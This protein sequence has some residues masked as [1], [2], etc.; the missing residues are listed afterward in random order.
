MTKPTIARDPH[1]F[2]VKCNTH[3]I[4]QKNLTR[5][6]ARALRQDSTWFCVG[7]AAEPTTTEATTS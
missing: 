3:E 1:G 7:C 2:T 6:T 5:K 4:S